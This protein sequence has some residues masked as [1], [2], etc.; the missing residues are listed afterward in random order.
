[1]FYLDHETNSGRAPFDC[2]LL[3]DEEGGRSVNGK[4]QVTGQTAD[5]DRLGLTGY[6]CHRTNEE[7]VQKCRER[8]RTQK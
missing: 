7:M 6:A 8:T 2:V 1:M 4:P 5:T 3:K